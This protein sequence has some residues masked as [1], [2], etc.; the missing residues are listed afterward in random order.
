MFSTIRKT[1]GPAV[2]GLIIGFIAFVFIFYG[3]FNPKATRGM[4]EGAVAGLVN[5]EKISLSEFN[6]AYEQRLEMF[7]S[8]GGG[9]ITEEQLRMFRIRESVFESL[10]DRKLLAQQSRALGISAGDEH[11]KSAIREMAVFRNEGGFDPL[12]YEQVLRANRYNPASF[13]DMMRED[14]SVQSL[15]ASLRGRVKVSE[16]EVREEFLR[17]QDKREIKYVLFTNE[18]GRKLFKVS[19]ADVTQ[20]LADEKN[21][22]LLKGQFERKKDTEFKGKAFDAVKQQLAEEQVGRDR[23]PQIR[24]ANEKYA[25]ELLGALGKDKAAD[26]R[27][28]AK[29][30]EL[31]GVVKTTGLLARSQGAIQGLGES[32]EILADAFSKASPIALGAGGKAKR[33]STPAGV[34]IAAVIASESPDESKLPSERAKL[35]ENLTQQKQGA[36]FQTWLKEVRKK[37]KI[38]PNP[39]VVSPGEEKAGA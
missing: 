20:F 7:K 22:N 32:K 5:G 12:R 26:D 9:K 24:T 18:M 2:V 21:V 3:V 1:F 27:L 11:V 14:L 17:T 34:V 38:D 33:Y 29:L 25:D 23:A 8:F 30:K 28:N 15:Q 16:A 39:D 10:V 35:L 13:E 6:R 37:A 36:V 31:G 19:P 4:H